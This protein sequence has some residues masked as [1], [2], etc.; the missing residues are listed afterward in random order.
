MRIQ[1]VSYIPVS[2]RDNSI[3]AVSPVVEASAER[4][5]NPKQDRPAYS[6]HQIKQR[7]SEP[8]LGGVVDTQV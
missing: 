3:E 1:D 4:P 6:Q 5:Y 7:F 2:K 8:G